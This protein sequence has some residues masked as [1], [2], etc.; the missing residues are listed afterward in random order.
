LAM[1]FRLFLMRTDPPPPAPGRSCSTRTTWHCGKQ[2]LS[3]P[4]AP[5]KRRATRTPS[6]GGQHMPAESTSTML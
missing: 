4:R 3:P 1:L 2:D 5:L 6:G